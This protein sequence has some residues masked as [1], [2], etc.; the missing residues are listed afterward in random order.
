MRHLLD[1]SELYILAILLVL[2][3]YLSGGINFSRGGI[4]D[5][6]A[7]QATSMSSPAPVANYA[8]SGLQ[9]MSL[10]PVI[11]PGL[12]GAFIVHNSADVDFAAQNGISYVITYNWGD[13]TWSPGGL[14][15]PNAFDLTS[16]GLGYG[17]ELVKNNIKTYLDLHGFI[18]YQNGNCAFD[19]TGA[20]DLINKYYQSP[21][22][23]GYWIKDDDVQQSGTGVYCD[24]KPA[25]SELH[26]LIRSIDPNTGHII[27]AGY[28]EP[29]GI[30]H[31]YAYGIA[32]VYA[33]YPYPAYDGNNVISYIDQMAQSLKDAAKAANK[34]TEPFV[35]VYQ[36]FWSDGNPTPNGQS[37]RFNAPT[38]S[39]IL[40]DVREFFKD[41]AIGVVAFSIGVP[42]DVN[43]VADND[44]GM[45]AIVQAVQNCIQTDP[46]CKPQ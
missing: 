37:K 4:I 38:S 6:T 30:Q 19:Q 40:T 5:T 22:L 44:A 32:D 31:N 39:D 11:G 46:T 17:T 18:T 28:G 2:S 26:Q 13:T 29:V 8:Q 1:N 33:F 27:M 24:M 43:K 25:L 36:A 41:G 3:L 20:T 21:V 16:D 42:E 10:I 35:G 34:P 15:T 45:A 23:G 14:D 9:I 12:H 7:P